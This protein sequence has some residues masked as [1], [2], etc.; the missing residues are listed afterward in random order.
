[1]RRMYGDFQTISNGQLYNSTSKRKRDINAVT[2]P[3]G[4]PDIMSAF[5]EPPDIPAPG[6]TANSGDSYFDNFRGKRQ[7]KLNPANRSSGGR[8]NRG[9]N[10]STE[11]TSGR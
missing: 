4:V 5:N 11:P 10:P 6:E 3:P 7:S 1:M 9:P 2:H 8:P